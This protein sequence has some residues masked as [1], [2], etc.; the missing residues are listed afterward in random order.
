MALHGFSRSELLLGTDGL[1]KLA[2][3]KVAIFGVGGVG[4]F[5][6]EAL[7]RSAVGSFVL[8]DDD[9]ICLTNLN[10]QIHATIKTIGKPKVEAMKERILDINPKAEVITFKKLYNSESADTLLSS[11]YDYV[12]DAIDMVSAKLDLIERCKNQLNIPIIS[13][14][15]AG[16]KLDPSLFEVTDIYSTSICPLAKV[17]RKELK[18]RGVKE[19]KVVYSKEEPIKPLKLNS[20][21][22]VDCICPNKDRTCTV[23]HQIPGSVSFVPSAVG[24][25]IASVVVRDLLGIY[26]K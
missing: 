13:S 9:D 10:R 3:S 22:K 26:I 15:G 25:I 14:M 16:N 7:A 20:D 24:L 4:T 19:L 1:D 12:I 21:C 6:V 2:K 23:R 5:A 18:K 8:V 17:M 11:D